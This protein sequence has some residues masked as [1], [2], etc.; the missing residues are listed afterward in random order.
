ML[1]FVTSIAIIFLSFILL[2]EIPFILASD[3]RHKYTILNQKA[4]K[5]FAPNNPILIQ[6]KQTKLLQG[7]STKE[8]SEL[9]TLWRSDLNKY[10]KE[11]NNYDEKINAESFR[12]YNEYYMFY[13]RFFAGL[14]IILFGLIGYFVKF[15][16]KLDILYLS[17][18]FAFLSFANVTQTHSQSIGSLSN[19]GLTWLVALILVYLLSV[20]L[21][22]KNN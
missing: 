3:E 12:I 18:S 8:Q 10:Q 14:V 13:S 11:K 4:I 1:K 5:D 17:L 21:K 9:H 6:G 15:Y 2:I 22:Q 16:N 7:K 19:I 20:S